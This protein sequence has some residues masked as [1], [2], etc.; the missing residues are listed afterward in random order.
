MK[1]NKKMI[2]INMLA[3]MLITDV[4]MASRIKGDRPTSTT[5]SGS[6]SSANVTTTSS[7]D[8]PYTIGQAA[9][10]KSCVSDM[11]SETTFPLELFTDLARDSNEKVDIQIKSGNKI[12]VKIPPVINVCGNFKPS[13]IQD[14]VTKNVTVM[15]QLFDTNKKLMSHKDLED[16]LKQKGIFVND[17]IQYDKVPRNGYTE[18]TTTLEYAFDSKS[19]VKKD[20]MISYAFAKSYRDSTGNGYNP[21]YG[22]NDNAPQIPN[23]PCLLSEKIAPA[24][25]YIN[26]GAGAWLEKINIAC[27]SGDVDRIISVRKSVGNATAL[28]DIMDKVIGEMDV[29]IISL[30]KPEAER[31][32]NEMAKIETYLNANRDAEESVIKKQINKYVDLTRELDTKFLNPAIYRLET[33]MKKRETIDDPESEEIVSIDAEIKSLNEE[34][35][36]FSKRNAASFATVYGAM[37]KYALTDSAKVVQE[38]RLKSALYSN[39]YPGKQDRSRGKQLTF[40]SAK[41][42]QTKKMQSFD[43][44]LSVW[45]DVY[46]VGQGNTFPLQRAERERQGGYDRLNTGYANFQKKEYTDYNKYCSA[47][48]TGGMRNPAKCNQ[49]MSGRDKRMNLYL[50]KREKDLYFIK[51]KND[52]LEKMGMSYSV[53]QRDIA[54]QEAE[55]NNYEPYGSSFSEFE[56]LY[57]ERFPSYSP[58]SLSGYQ[59]SMID[60][61]NMNGMMNLGQTPMMIS[62]Q[63]QYNPQPGYQ[64]QMPQQQQQQQFGPWPMLQ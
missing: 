30:S 18:S 61:G 44:T 29:A 48:M 2:A 14:T 22:L 59:S 15:I 55:D 26:E 54:S 46:L 40:E 39:V 11:D 21:I 63:Q 60:Y 37:E 19:D 33:I 24:T 35:G 53:Y 43:K 62:Q 12:V 1:L 5:S 31:I 32:S 9:E 34:I 58:T 45:T 16:C 7:V 56:D 52:S 8:N 64:Y 51:G 10:T 25:T 41:K 20:V 13:T 38:V 36:K 6:G 4:A 17:K 23:H 57:S 28:T 49:F 3:T 50:K 42:E 47:G 27:E